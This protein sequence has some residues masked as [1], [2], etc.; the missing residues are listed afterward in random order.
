[1]DHRRGSGC[2]PPILMNMRHRSIRMFIRAFLKEGKVTASP[3]Y[4]K[5]EKVREDIQ[6]MLI[7]RIASGDI[8]SQEELED[9]FATVGMASNALKSV[10]FQVFAATAKKTAA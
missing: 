10:P 7:Q 5:K 3:A 9:F 8:Q 1:M 4:V 2:D 6:A